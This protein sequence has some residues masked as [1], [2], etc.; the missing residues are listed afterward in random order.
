MF[1]TLQTN[2]TCKCNSQRIF[3]NPTIWFQITLANWIT[4]INHSL[5]VTLASVVSYLTLYFWAKYY[6]YFSIFHN[7]GHLLYFGHN[8]YFIL[9][10]TTMYVPMLVHN[11]VVC[12]LQPI[13]SQGQLNLKSCVNGICGFSLKHRQLHFA[14]PFYFCGKLKNL[15]N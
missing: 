5:S 14:F 4:S 11:L 3:W 15:E 6:W 13:A 10:G 9:F 7:S 1:A 12:G 8:I 2:C